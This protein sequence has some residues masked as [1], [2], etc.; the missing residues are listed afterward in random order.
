MPVTDKS[1]FGRSL[2]E[3]PSASDSRDRRPAEPA[4]S[5]SARS[6]SVSASRKRRLS[7]KVGLL[8]ALSAERNRS[9]ASSNA[10]TACSLGR[11]SPTAKSEVWLQL[12][13]WAQ[14]NTAA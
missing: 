13:P 3:R 11:G 9:I 14:R 7:A 10:R 6:A 12:C 2:R 5:R 4:G 8:P 1:W